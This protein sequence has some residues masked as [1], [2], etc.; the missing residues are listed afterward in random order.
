VQPIRR[1]NATM[2]IHAN[3]AIGQSEC[4]D[5]GIVVTFFHLGLFFLLYHITEII[6]TGESKR[7][8]SAR[9]Y[10]IRRIY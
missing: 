10:N 3:L 4:L 1:R 2:A 5:I 7:S 8:I 9:V 6:A